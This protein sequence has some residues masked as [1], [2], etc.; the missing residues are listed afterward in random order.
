MKKEPSEAVPCSALVL[1]LREHRDKSRAD[2]KRL[3]QTLA[4]VE[5][6][7]D[8]ARAKAET[9]EEMVELAERQNGRVEQRR[10][11]HE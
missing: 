4:G 9:A 3:E 10:T 7:L 8:R 11:A 2:V 6:A 1:A 5:R